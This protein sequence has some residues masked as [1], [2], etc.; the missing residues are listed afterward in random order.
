M[1]SRIHICMTYLYFPDLCGLN[2]KCV[3]FT[4]HEFLSRLWNLSLVACDH[5]L[6]L[7]VATFR[8]SFDGLWNTHYSVWMPC[9]QPRA[10]FWVTNGSLMQAALLCSY[11]LGFFLVPLFLVCTHGSNTVASA[12]SFGSSSE[13]LTLQSYFFLWAYSKHAA[14]WIIQ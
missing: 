11:P 6:F 5:P 9:S 3:V 10:T 4:N 7:K 2:S 1:V 12:G 8:Q 14:N 13:M